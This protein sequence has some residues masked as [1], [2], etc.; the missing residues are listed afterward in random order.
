VLPLLLWVE[1]LALAAVGAAWLYR[2]WPR[3]STY[4]VTTPVLALLVLQVFDNLTPMLPS[5]L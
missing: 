4:L 5:T 1:L 3:W 2:R